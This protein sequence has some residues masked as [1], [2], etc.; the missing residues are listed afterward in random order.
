MLRNARTRVFAIDDPI[1]E[2]VE[3]L[4]ARGSSVDDRG[5]ACAEGIAVGIQAVVAGI[6]SA[7]AGS[8]I[9]VHVNVDEPRRH[10]EPGRIDDFQGVD[11][12]DVRGHCRHF[13]AC[14]GDI[15]DGADVVPGIDEVTAL[16]QEIVLLLRRHMNRR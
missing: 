3:I 11:R 2:I 6:R 14:N 13:P 1:L 7:F 8:G 15:A 10:V 5:D 4:P 9:H 12:A 16:Q